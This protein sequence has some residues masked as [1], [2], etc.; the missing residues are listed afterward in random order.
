MGGQERLIYLW[1]GA[2]WVKALGDG[3]G[4]FQ[5]DILT[6][7]ALIS[8][9]YG[10][11]GANWQTVLVES[12]ANPNLRVR[13]YGGANFVAVTQ[14]AAAHA[15]TNYGLT[16]YSALY[17]DDGTNLSRLDMLLAQQ[18]ALA[19]TFNGLGVTA[20]PYGFNG[21][22]WD[23]LRTYLTGILK[24][25]RAEVGLSNSGVLSA[26]AQVKAAAGNVYWL[27]VSDTAVLAIEL[28]DGIADAGVDLWGIDLPAGGYLHLV[29][30]PPIE[31][32]TGIWLDVSTATCKV[33][34][35]YL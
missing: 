15:R 14:S 5:V 1:D 20:M 35:G 31:F 19:N 28:N 25:G 9:I 23:R 29:F 7:P 8:H 4:H 18:D 33:T 2:E 11:D 34:I 13:L 24:V 27:T 32:G 26:D 17:A 30:D 6:A 3:A 21:A 12:A 16:T 22:T 10:Y